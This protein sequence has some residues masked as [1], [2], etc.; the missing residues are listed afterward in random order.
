MFC[1][2]NSDRICIIGIIFFF[3]LQGYGKGASG[4]ASFSDGRSSATVYRS[5]TARI[6][7]LINLEPDLAE[8]VVF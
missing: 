5:A 1:C 6:L 3:S 7:V 4:E 2:K 8:K